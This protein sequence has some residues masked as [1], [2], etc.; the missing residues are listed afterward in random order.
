[1]LM[2]GKRLETYRT[3]GRAVLVSGNLKKSPSSCPKLCPNIAS[4]KQH[5]TPH[6]PK[7][8]PML[9]C[10]FNKTTHHPKGCLVVAYWTQSPK[11]APWRTAL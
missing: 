10:R 1:M 11:P 6:R 7:V 2:A 4:I 8:Y 5:A 3:Q 9:E